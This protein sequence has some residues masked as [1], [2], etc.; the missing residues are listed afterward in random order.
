MEPSEPPLDPLLGLVASHCLAIWGLCRCCVGSQKYQRFWKYQHQ[1]W[2]YL[3]LDHGIP[4]RSLLEVIQH[5]HL[6]LCRSLGVVFSPCGA[7]S[8]KKV[9]LSLFSPS[10][11]AQAGFLC[12]IVVPALQFFLKLIFN[13]TCNQVECSNFR[14]CIWRLCWTCSVSIFNS[15]CTSKCLLQ[16]GHLQRKS[17]LPCLEPRQR[18][19]VK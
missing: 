9:C 7:I 3:L 8:S 5:T 1:F 19:V 15:S 4:G 13:S 16:H 18:S 2:K 11:I 14:A 17:A 12:H 10:I 6:R